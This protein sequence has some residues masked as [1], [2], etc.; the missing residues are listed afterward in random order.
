MMFSLF[1]SKP[2]LAHSAATLQNVLRTLTARIQTLE[3]K[4]QSMS[5][6]IDALG[7][8]VTKV[9][10]DVNAKLASLSTSGLSDA[11]KA[12]VASITSAL[13]ALDAQVNPPA[14][15]PAPVVTPPAA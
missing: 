2:V 5:Q 4:V 13:T 1:K 9:V 15:A 14:L 12:T 6:E 10:A 3:S 8:L 7:A 11:D